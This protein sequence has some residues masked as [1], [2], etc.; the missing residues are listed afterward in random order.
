MILWMQAI[1]TLPNCFLDVSS[2]D[3]ANLLRIMETK[4]ASVDWAQTRH[5]HAGGIMKMDAHQD[6]HERGH[7]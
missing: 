3:T 4:D 6:Y 5:L 1:T 7:R 2:H